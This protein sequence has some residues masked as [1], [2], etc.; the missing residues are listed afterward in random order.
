MAAV[1][2]A[3]P[4]GLA[5]TAASAATGPVTPTKEE[6]G[7][8]FTGAQFRYAQATVYLRNASQYSASI[9]GLGQSVQFW[10]GGN[11]YV[12]GVFDSTTASPYSPAV[13][14]FNNSTHALVCATSNNTCAGTPASW[15]SGAVSYPVGHSVQE[16]IFYNTGNG[17]FTFT[18]NDLTA[19]TTSGFTLN[20]GTGVSFKEVRIG[21]EFG[22]TPWSV[23]SFTPPA[24]QLKAAAFSDGRLT[25]Y[26]GTRYGFS[27]YFTTSPLIMTGPGSVT[28]ANAGALNSTADGFSIFLVP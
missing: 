7:Y 26:E 18:V 16:D 25:N 15:T 6:A 14:V 27:G 9:G 24:S 19:G 3:L 8:Q 4:A 11:V 17:D 23:P 5:A 2:L 22:D 28:E 20:I 10:G 12:L 13:A 1:V 21:S